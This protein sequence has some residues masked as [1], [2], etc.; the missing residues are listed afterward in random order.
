MRSKNFNLIGNA[1]EKDIRKVAT[2]FEQFRETLRLLFSKMNLS[3]PIATNVV[4]FKSNSAYKPFKPK[5]AAFQRMAMMRQIKESLRKPL[6]GEKREM[7]FIEK[8]ECSNKGLF[9]YFKIQTAVLK[10]S[11]PTP[12]TLQMKAFMPDTENMQ[13]GC[14]MK[15]VEIPVIITYKEIPDKKSKTS[16]EL[17]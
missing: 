4:V 5:R 8:S 11:N 9:F 6:P 2:K 12:Q 10:L 14:G 13:I 3:S 17:V 16:G 1:S 7:A 15:A